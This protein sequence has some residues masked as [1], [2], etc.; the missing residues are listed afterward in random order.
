MVSGIGAFSENSD[1]F[2]A[3]EI[4]AFFKCLITSISPSFLPSKIF[5]LCHYQYIVIFICV[6]GVR[7][8]EQIRKVVRPMGSR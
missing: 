3:R 4:E 5:V 6:F 7:C 8:V 1:F 2:V